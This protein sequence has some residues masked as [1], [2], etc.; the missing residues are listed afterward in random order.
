MSR[1][2]TPDHDGE[3]FAGLRVSADLDFRAPLT[4]AG[5][6]LPTAAAELL[7]D[8]LHRLGKAYAPALTTSL[9]SSC[10][11]LS[12]R[13]PA[14]ASSPRFGLWLQECDRQGQ[15]GRLVASCLAHR[16]VLVQAQQ[17]PGNGVQFWLGVDATCGDIERLVRVLEPLVEALFHRRTDLLFRHLGGPKNPV[18]VHRGAEIGVGD[19]DDGRADTALFLVYEPPDPQTLARLD[20]SLLAYD[21][22]AARSAGQWLAARLRPFLLERRAASVGS[23]RVLLQQVCFPSTRPADD[24]SAIEAAVA[25]AC[26]VDLG[27]GAR[28]ALSQ[29]SARRLAARKEHSVAA[30]SA[31]AAAKHLVRRAVADV[32]LPQLSGNELSFEFMGADAATEREL[33]EYWQGA[34]PPPAN[35]ARPRIEVLLIFPEASTDELV[36]RPSSLVLDL[37][38]VLRLRPTPVSLQSNVLYGRG[39]SLQIFGQPLTSTGPLGQH[40]VD[41]EPLA[42]LLELAAAP[43]R[44]SACAGSEALVDE[45]GLRVTAIQ[46]FWGDITPVEW[47]AFQ[48]HRRVL[49]GSEPAPS[50]LTILNP[51]LV[52]PDQSPLNVCEHVFCP[53]HLSSSSKVIA[54]A[55]GDA[56]SYAELRIRASAYAHH[57]RSLGL[58]PGDVV[59]LAAPDGLESV[60][61]LLGCLMGGWVLAPLNFHSEANLRVMLDAANPQLVLY[62]RA[63]VPSLAS[64]TEAPAVALDPALTLEEPAAAAVTFPAVRVPPGSAALVL[65]TSGSTGTPKAVAHSHRDLLTCSRNYA[66]YVLGLSSADRVHTPSPMFFAY[67][68]HNLMLSLLAG[69]T[70]VVAAPKA[71]GVLVAD[72]LTQYEITALLAVP[73]VYKLLLSRVPR[74]SSFPRLRLCVSAGEKLPPRLFREL[75]LLLGVEPLDGIGCTEALSTFVSNRPSYASASCTGVVVPGFAVRLLNEQGELCDI[76]EVGTLWLRG[77]PLAEAYMT[78]PELTKTTFADGWFKTRDLFYY[79]AEYRFYNVGRASS[80]IKINGCW[81]SAESVESVLQTHPAVRECVVS[82]V[83]DQYRLPRP[84]ALVVVDAAAGYDHDLERLWSE[85]RALSRERL[86]KD[87]YPHLFAKVDAVPRTASGKLMRPSLLPLQAGGGLETERVGSEGAQ[88]SWT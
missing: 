59:A 83:S 25:R 88:L 66:A 50:E 22:Q 73:A 64:Y 34:L 11:T 65:F 68:I 5:P 2:D 63:C 46:G 61:I 32:V 74:A 36:L 6:T 49:A 53:A 37:F 1:R 16:G 54:P 9:A 87:Q 31:A 42:A 48:S 38:G 24:R 85:L 62:D 33:R 3:A 23:Q 8:H 72:V 86:G 69:A 79:D 26:G 82:I 80:T 18:A 39:V 20:A 67:G 30:R 58:E 19:L 29:A 70:H 45:L 13:C 10:F 71:S 4:S 60:A 12:L 7:S 41:A 21:D 75:Q 78:D 52:P 44:A 57:F 77:G 35:P 81:F 17:S 40:G 27:R 43:G 28:V 47:C 55:T 56:L 14:D 84:K 15:L 76:G 51:S